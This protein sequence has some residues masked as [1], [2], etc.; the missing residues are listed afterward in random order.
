MWTSIN[1]FLVAF[2]FYYSMKRVR[3]SQFLY[4]CEKLGYRSLI[5]K[6]KWRITTMR[7]LIKMGCDLSRRADYVGTCGR[8]GLAKI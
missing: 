1:N 4:Y 8:Y 3:L 7:Q 5:R 6:I 2:T